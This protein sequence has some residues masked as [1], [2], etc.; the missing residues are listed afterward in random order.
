MDSSV[1]QIVLHYFLFHD[2]FTVFT[3]K[4]IMEVKCISFSLQPHHHGSNSNTSSLSL[5]FSQRQAS[6]SSLKGSGEC[7]PISI[8]EGRRRGPSAPIGRN[9][10]KPGGGEA[11]SSWYMVLSDSWRNRRAYV[12]VI[13][14]WIMS[15]SSWLGSKRPPPHGQTSPDMFPNLPSIFDPRMGSD[16]D[17]LWDWTEMN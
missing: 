1:E 17:T 5:T 14:F 8:E 6:C 15:D 4:H 9:N 10:W 7:W 2:I 11:L 12:S 16:Q 13:H 3:G